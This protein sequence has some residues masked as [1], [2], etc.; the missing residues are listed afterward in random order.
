MGPVTA[1]DPLR[2]AL[3]TARRPLTHG[4]G[5]AQAQ[6]AR[7][8]QA[9]GCVARGRAV[10]VPGHAVTVPHARDRV[11]GAQ[12]LSDGELGARVASAPWGSPC[13]PAP[14]P[15]LRPPHA[16]ARKPAEGARFLCSLLL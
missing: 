8:P 6:R 5:D 3:G 12:T 10:T 7:A 13:R 11:R 15:A 14:R 2:D 9:A 16:R 4:V 1:Q